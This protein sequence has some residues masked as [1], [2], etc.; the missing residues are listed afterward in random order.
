[1]KHNVRITLLMIFFFF[2]T[3]IMGIVIVNNYIDREQTIIKGEPVFSDL[4]LGVERPEVEESTSY[5]YIFISIIIG[6][7]L[8]F[9]IMYFNAELFWK[10]WFLLSVF[11]ALN[12]AFKA[13]IGNEMV[14][15]ILSALFSAWKIFKPNILVH[16]FTELFIY[17]GLAALLVD[18]MNIK[19]VSI[20][21]VL[22]SFYDMYAVWKSK[23]MIKLAEYQSKMNVFAGFFIPYS[24]KKQ[25]VASNVF[26]I[27]REDTGKNKVAI[28]GGGDIGFPIMFTGVV[29]KE[30]VLTTP[31]FSTLFLKVLPIPLLTTLA[32]ALLFFYSK[33]NKFYPAMPFVSAGCF[34]GYLITMLF[35]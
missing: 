8:I 31:E 33:K 1:M 11:I 4:P 18:I 25:K 24:L 23:H 21:L 29:M 7:A 32:L 26:D 20:L 17:G 27:Q 3:Q 9:L 28:L 22:I 12:F 35:I 6:T 2:I 5:I 30:L 19:S 13:F 16:N 14:I 10:L 15:V 34:L